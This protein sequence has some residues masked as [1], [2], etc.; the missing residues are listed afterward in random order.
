MRSASRGPLSGR[1]TILVQHARHAQ[2]EEDETEE[3]ESAEEDESPSLNELQSQLQT[4]E[5]VTND[6]QCSLLPK[7][8]T[9]CRRIRS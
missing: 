2:D 7:Q 8:L 4:L 5:K 3:K 9:L 1:Q 6:R